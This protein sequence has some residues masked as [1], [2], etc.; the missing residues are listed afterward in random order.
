MTSKISFCCREREQYIKDFSSVDDKTA[1]INLNN[2]IGVHN[3]S[4]I[5][6]IPKQRKP[7]IQ[8]S[9]TEAWNNRQ[10]SYADIIQRICTP[11]GRA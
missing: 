4:R 5:K 1:G 2:G 7:K 8:D 6:L 11:L 3:N 10:L 9:P